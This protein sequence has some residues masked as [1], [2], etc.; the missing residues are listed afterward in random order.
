M[1]FRW[2]KHLFFL[3]GLFELAK[4]A[5]RLMLTVKLQPWVSGFFLKRTSATHTRAEY[6]TTDSSPPADN[7]A[8]SAPPCSIFLQD[9]MAEDREKPLVLFSQPPQQQSAESRPPTIRFHVTGASEGHYWDY[10]ALRAEY[11]QMEPEQRGQRT[12]Q[13]SPNTRFTKTC[14]KTNTWLVLEW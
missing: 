12:C 5:S 14:N 6:E 2:S 13:S 8:D 7:N 3:S 4:T 1:T 11:R 9:L 10:R